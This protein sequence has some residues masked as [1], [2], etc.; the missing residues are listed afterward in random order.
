MSR[1]D[2]LVLALGE[3]KVVELVKLA[4]ALPEAKLD[5][6]ARKFARGGK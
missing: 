2:A 1:L 4:A 5:D 3:R 6:A